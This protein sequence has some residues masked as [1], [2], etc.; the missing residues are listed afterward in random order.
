MQEALEGSA[1]SYQ[2]LRLFEFAGQS[3]SLFDASGRLE[4]KFRPAEIIF[5]STKKGVSDEPQPNKDPD[6]R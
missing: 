1:E 5:A 4:Q 3:A 6:R 2:K